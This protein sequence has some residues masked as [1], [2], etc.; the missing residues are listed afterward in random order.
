MRKFLFQNNEF[1]HIYNRGVDKWRIF[2]ND[3]D[4]IRFLIS[5]R[6]FNNFEISGSLYS[7]NNKTKNKVKKGSKIPIGSLVPSD[8]PL[9]EIISYCLLP[10]HYHFMLKQITENGMAKFFHK[11]NTG[12]TNYYNFKNKRTG[13]LFEGPYKSIHVKTS[14]YLQYLSCYINGNPEIHKIS[15]AESWIWSSY[16]DYLGLRNGTLSNKRI[17]LD[18]FN[19]SNQY[20]LLVNEIIIESIE[21]K[22]EIKKYFLE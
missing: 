16:K 8:T 19:N 10:N 14:S 13:S 3:K 4:Y 1:Y 18:E 2:D 17:V 12:Y 22:D 6:E 21:R 7:K 5:V 9:I 15:K 11:L 20:K